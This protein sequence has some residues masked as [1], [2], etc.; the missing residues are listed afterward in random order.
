MAQTVRVEA[1]SAELNHL[2]DSLVGVPIS[3]HLQNSF[4]DRVKGG[5][6]IFHVEQDSFSAHTTIEGRLRIVLKPAEWFVKFVAAT[7]ASDRQ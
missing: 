4:L 6:Q 3:L 2:L 5:A 1:D 7:L